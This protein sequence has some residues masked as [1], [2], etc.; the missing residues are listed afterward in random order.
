MDILKRKNDI[1]EQISLLE[2]KQSYY[3][4]ERDRLEQEMILVLDKMPG[5][6]TRIREL[7]EQLENLSSIGD[8]LDTLDAVAFKVWRTDEDY[9]QNQEVFHEGVV[10]KV[11]QDHKSQ[12]DWLPNEVPSLYMELK[13]GMVGSDPTKQPAEWERP[14]GGHNSYNLGDKVFYKGYIYESLIDGNTTAPDEDEP[15]NRFWLK[16]K[17][18]D[19]IS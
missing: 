4:E 16:I 3:R 12:G 1:E 18:D 17:E 2:E 15:H 19:K 7:K 6:A 11:L 14:T 10:Y 5:V 8:A 13:A 9:F